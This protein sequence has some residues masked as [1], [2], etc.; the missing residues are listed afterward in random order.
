VGLAEAFLS[1]H[2]GGSY[3]PLTNDELMASSLRIKDG[4]NG[5]PGL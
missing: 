1:A 5:V 4:K 2:L 3:A